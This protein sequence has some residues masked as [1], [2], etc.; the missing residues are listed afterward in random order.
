MW[1]KHWNLK[2][3]LPAFSPFPLKFSKA[4]F[5]WVIK[6]HKC[7]VKGLIPNSSKAP[8]TRLYKAR[9]KRWDRKGSS[10]FYLF[11]TQSQV[12]RTQRKKPLENIV[13]KGENAGDQHF[14]LFSQYFLPL[15]NKLL[16]L[17]HIHFV[18]CKMLWIWTSPTF[19]PLVKS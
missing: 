10:T 13:E 11:T 14:L 3:W 5:P 15:P 19:C 17:S 16:V 2:T 6:S 12:L 9:C 8:K 7:V 18:V 4:F 1:L